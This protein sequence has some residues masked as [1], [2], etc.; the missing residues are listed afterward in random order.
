M[1]RSI[2]FLFILASACKNSKIGE[3]NVFNGTQNESPTQNAHDS[4]SGS[5]SSSGTGAA[6]PD[7]QGTY[8]PPSADP[9]LLANSD[10]SIDGNG[11]MQGTNVYQQISPALTDERGFPAAGPK[12]IILHKTAGKV[13][14]P[15]NTV[16]SG[17]EKPHIYICQDGRV[18]VNGSF[19]WPRTRAERGHNSWSLNVEFESPYQDKSKCAERGELTQGGWGHCYEPLTPQQIAMGKKVIELLSKRYN[20]PQQLAL[21]IENQQQYA[22][23][24]TLILPSGSSTLG[25]PRNVTV[26][27]MPKG[28]LPSYWTALNQ[29]DNTNHDDGPS[30]YDL[31]ALGIP[32]MPLPPSQNEADAAPPTDP[33]QQQARL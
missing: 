21:P 20:I 27:E 15:N 25:G 1:K 4:T 13:C 7:S 29:D 33:T 8:K 26:D 6:S 22:A 11:V 18:I 30:W 10:L 24:Q 17:Y 23:E 31:Q 3:K 5:G 2:V 16:P 19:D 9:T 12:G 28:I 32:T 14:N